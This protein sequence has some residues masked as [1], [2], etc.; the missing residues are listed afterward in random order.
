VGWRIFGH[1]EWINS[2]PTDV[3]SD[4]D[5]SNHDAAAMMAEICAKILL[6]SAQIQTARIEE[7]FSWETLDYGR[8]DD[9]GRC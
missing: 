1:K 2:I 9:I 6:S 8:Q 4:L 7:G 5:Y 3:L